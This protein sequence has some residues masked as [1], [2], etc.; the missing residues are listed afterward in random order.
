MKA[1][2]DAVA[3]R[4]NQLAML[5]PRRR[6]GL[7]RRLLRRLHRSPRIHTG[8]TRWLV[9][10][11]SG[12]VEAALPGQHV[13]PSLL[14]DAVKELERGVHKVERAARRT[15]RVPAA[16]LHWLWRMYQILYRAQ[17]LIVE[18]EGAWQSRL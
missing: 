17:Q 11:L 1:R 12:E 9:K 3:R 15:G 14:L 13:L 16:Q 2:L 8:R 4:L 5:P 6:L 10:K 7:A 18:P